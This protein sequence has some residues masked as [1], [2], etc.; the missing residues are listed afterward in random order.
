M[1]AREADL[2]LTL[3]H[4]RELDVWPEVYGRLAEGTGR[5]LRIKPRSSETP[6]IPTLTWYWAKSYKRIEPWL[7]DYDVKLIQVGLRIDRAV[8]EPKGARAYHASDIA[9]MVQQQF[10]EHGGAL[11]RRGTPRINVPR[12]PGRPPARP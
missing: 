9:R 11:V 12:G 3:D 5:M 2:Y 7:T 6:D 1:T 10:G 8:S 4:N